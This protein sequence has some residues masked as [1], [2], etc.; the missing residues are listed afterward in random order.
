MSCT[1]RL[2]FG[3][4]TCEIVAVSID[5]EDA[6]STIAWRVHGLPTSTTQLLPLPK[7]LG[8][9]LAVSTNA[10]HYCNQFYRC[11]LAVNG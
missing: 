10:L 4:H 11:G 1:E 9:V 8:G 6:S 2:A 5:L 3:N 7:P